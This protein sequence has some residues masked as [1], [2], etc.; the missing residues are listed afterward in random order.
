MIVVYLIEMFILQIEKRGSIKLFGIY[1][2]FFS[3][4]L[5]SALSV[6]DEGESREARQTHGINNVLM[7]FLYIL[8]FHMVGFKQS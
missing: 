2:T 7:S 8:G 4:T 3:R 5:Y 6:P 1:E